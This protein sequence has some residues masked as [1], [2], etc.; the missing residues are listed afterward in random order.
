MRHFAQLVANGKT[1][2]Q[3]YVSAGYSENGA[4]QSANRLLKSAEVA[5]RVE[6]LRKTVRGS[7]PVSGRLSPLVKGL[8]GLNRGSWHEC[9]TSYTTRRYGSSKTKAVDRPCDADIVLPLLEQARSCRAFVREAATMW[10][11]ALQCAEPAT[12]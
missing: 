6:E 7:R 10:P 11:L 2:P 8:G 4:T 1:P 9:C 3:A 5:V 12:D